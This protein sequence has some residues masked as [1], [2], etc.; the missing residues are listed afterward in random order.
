MLK[1]TIVVIAQPSLQ[2]LKNSVRVRKTEVLN[3]FK[4]IILKK[5]KKLV[6]KMVFPWSVHIN[7]ELFLWL[8]PRRLKLQPQASKF[9]DLKIILALRLFRASLI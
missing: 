1:I 9:L 6:F 4:E 2:P 8:S 5:L 7:F 3:D